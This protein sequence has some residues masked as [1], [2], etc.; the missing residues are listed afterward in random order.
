VGTLSSLAVTGNLT[1]DTNTLV[2]DA[3]NNRVGVGTASPSYPL[4]IA[5]ASSETA[6]FNVDSGITSMVNTDQ[7][8]NNYALTWY[9]DAVGGAAS[10]ITGV[11]FTDHT[12]NYGAFLWA[13]RGTSG[14]SERM[15]L[16]S[17]GNLGLGVT[18]SAW[19]D[20]K[21]IQ[22]PQ[23]A[24]SSGSEFGIAVA[25]GAYRGASNV[26]R[27][28]NTSAPAV[29]LYNQLN[30]RHEWF[31]A[32]SGT[33]GNAISFTQAM[34]LDASGNLGINSPATNARLEVV[35]TTGEVFRADA[36]GGAPRV[37]ADQSKVVIGGDVALGQFT[38]DFGGGVR[39]IAIAEATT[40]PTSNPTGR[41]ILY[42]ESGAL[43]YRGSSGTVTTIAN[44]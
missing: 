4:H 3:A 37:V 2:V 42:V 39:V 13:T 38:T 20:D 26:W 23:G 12:N 21:A 8:N 16:D 7:T 17:N 41:G 15:R 30:G 6:L 18:P 10:A 35:A 34:T 9:T 1:V 22:L 29:S 25:A 11:Q 44:A 31:T 33:A 14:L 24:V 27:Y 36:S 28:F 5:F 43:K 32:P 40:V 19:G